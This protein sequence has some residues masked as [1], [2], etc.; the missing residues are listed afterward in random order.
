MSSRD[1][2]RVVRPMIEPKPERVRYA[3]TLA[4]HAQALRDPSAMITAARDLRTAGRPDKALE[5]LEGFRR[6][7][8]ANSS[9]R[10]EQ[11][12][13]L[14]ALGRP[15]DAIREVQELL[16]A[17]PEAPATLRLIA[18]FAAAPS[19][20]AIDKANVRTL[21][22][23]TVTSDDPVGVLKKMRLKAVGTVPIRHVLGA[24]AGLALQTRL[25]LLSRTIALKTIYRA[26]DLTA[27]LLLALARLWVWRSDIRIASLGNFTRL[28]DV[29]DRIDPVLRR[30][31]DESKGRRTPLQIHAFV[32]LF[33]AAL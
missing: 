21:L 28:A 7:T 31:R 22:S 19:V 14:A 20:G 24:G 29:V 4:R 10:L 12:L 5:T 11:S 2:A 33:V 1:P 15:G 26:L 9:W 18:A 27:I 30:L 13:T 3:R 32:R 25:R 17:D 23:E 16:D 6:E 8:D